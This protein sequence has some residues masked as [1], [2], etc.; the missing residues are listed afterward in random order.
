MKLIRN[1]LII[2][3]VCMILSGCEP[4][5][6]EPT[7]SGSAT[8]TTENITET[9][10]SPTENEQENK[11]V[12]P[13]LSIQ[14]KSTD[15]NVM[16]FI[17][18][19]IAK[20]V[21]DDIAAYEPSFERP[22]EPYYEDCT[23]MLKS[24]DGETLLQAAD[25]QVKVR[26]NWTTLYP[27]KP[28]RIKFESKQNL[29]G[30]NDGAEFKNW[31]LLAEYKDASMLRNKSA[32]YAAREILSE[33]GLY[34]PDAEF[35]Q[36]EVNGEYQGMYLLTEM[37]QTN[38]NRVNI[39]EPEKDYAGTDIGYFLEF[40]GYYTNED[41][42]HSFPLE[43][44]DNAPLVPYDGNGGSSR[45]IQ[46]IT[47]PDSDF[48]KDIGMTIHSDIYSQEQHDFIENYVNCVYRIM[49]EAAYNDKAFTFDED[50]SSISETT[51]ITPRQAVENVVDI[52]SLA[53]MYIISELT[54]D[55]DITWSSFYMS[56]D[57]SADGNKKL[58]FQ[59]PWDFDSSMG[60]R[61]YCTDGQGFH[62]AN[63]VPDPDTSIDTANPWLM[64]L[65]YEE[66]YQDIVKN[67]WTH[68]SDSGIPDKMLDMIKSDAGNF[69]PDFEQNY[70]K[71]NNIIVNYYFADELS[72]PAKKV[73][74]ESQA[75]DFL[76]EWLGKRIDFLN[77]QWYIS[78]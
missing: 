7:S 37:L 20:Q 16:S 5:G 38:K 46:C 62:A 71:W 44:A 53:D 34:A 43:L 61:D 11:T 49:Y 18:E 66:W 56:A 21:S 67:K 40:D 69:Q 22:P 51:G 74:N 75:A 76:L 47:P 63:I 52:A 59:A 30:L 19:P 72:E 26:G 73:S 55:A 3:F 25:A 15:E 36:V 65:A 58:T 39:N 2:S 29:L 35:V 9:A 13:V 78:H 77:S 8:D 1:I 70:S 32:F 31:L 41:K 24:A 33:D 6:S 23:V 48:H 50:Y 60:N 12:L 10:V 14:T 45:T 64:V 54:C 57:L 27:K 17:S 4:H 28:L 68:I 42:L